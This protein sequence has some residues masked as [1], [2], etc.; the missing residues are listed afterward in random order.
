MSYK[1][2]VALTFDIDWAP[3]FV[4]EQCVNLLLQYSIP[5]TFFITHPSPLTQCLRQDNQFEVGIHPNFLPYSSHG[6][7]ILDVMN[8]MAE[9]VPEAKVMRTHGLYQ[10]TNLFFTIIEHFD[11]INYDV[12]LFLPNNN[13][14]QPFLFYD[15][16]SKKMIRIPFQWEDD[17]F[18]LCRVEEKKI[19]KAIFKNANYQ[20]FNFHPIHVYLN[21]CSS[22]QYTVMKRAMD[23][24][25]YSAK[26]K[27]VDPFINSK[28]GASNW[29]LSIINS[30]DK[31]R[32]VFCSEIAQHF[33]L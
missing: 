27:Q 20:I 31:D 25:L 10:S 14:C 32:F 6:E 1:F 26:K 16:N 22:S 13:F 4:V 28:I 3:D 15:E 17:V 19:E 30:I 29:L 18:F 7:S 11:K 24:S 23:E 12:S 5:T 2:P 9:I 21:S 33:D 8:Y